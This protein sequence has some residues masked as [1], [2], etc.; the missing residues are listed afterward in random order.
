MLSFGQYA[1][2][3]HSIVTCRMFLFGLA[4]LVY[5]EM[6]PDGKEKKTREKS[7]SGK[8]YKG[9][10]WSEESLGGFIDDVIS[11][12]TKLA[13]LKKHPK[14]TERKPMTKQSKSRGQEK[15]LKEERA[16]RRAKARGGAGA[17]AETKGGADKNKNRVNVGRDGKM[18]KSWEGRKQEQQQ[19]EREKER[20]RREQM[21]REAENADGIEYVGDDGNEEDVNDAATSDSDDLEVEEIVVDGDTGEVR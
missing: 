15:D 20:R 8:S 13:K 7:F 3:S 5:M 18:S 6:N 2:L 19:D 10:E 14:V 9:S 21:L 1:E 11:K 17:R 16:E 12:K 4:R